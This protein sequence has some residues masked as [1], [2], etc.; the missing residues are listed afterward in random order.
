M[1]EKKT[2]EVMA[3]VMSGYIL[4]YCNGCPFYGIEEYE[5]EQVCDSKMINCTWM[6]LW[7]YFENA[8][9]EEGE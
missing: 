5:I 2:S 6:R 1:N 4:N 8:E 7:K 9:K 3:Q